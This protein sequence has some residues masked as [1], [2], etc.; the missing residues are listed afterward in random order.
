MICE[1]FSYAIM[2]GVLPLSPKNNINSKMALEYTLYDVLG[3]SVLECFACCAIAFLWLDIC[4]NAPRRPRNA[5]Q[6]WYYHFLAPVLKFML[7]FLIMTALAAGMDGIKAAVLGT[8]SSS[9]ALVKIHSTIQVIVWGLL[10]LVM[11]QCVNLT[12]SR[13]LSITEDNRATL[14]QKAVLPMVLTSM[15]CLL[16][17]IWLAVQLL[18]GQSTMQSASSSWEYW[19]GFVWFPTITLVVSTLYAA[20][21]RDSSSNN[22]QI[23]GGAPGNDNDLARPLLMSPVPPSE[24]FMSFRNQSWDT[25]ARGESGDD[26]ENDEE[27]APETTTTTTTTTTTPVAAMGTKKSSAEEQQQ[28]VAQSQLQPPAKEPPA[29]DNRMEPDAD[30]SQIIDTPDVAELNL[31]M[32]SSCNQDKPKSEFS[33]AQLK[34]QVS[35]RKCKV[36]VESN[37]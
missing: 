34:K 32:C 16:R 36:C 14:L 20:R 1:V 5:T 6:P 10:S 37:A 7:V 31:M 28:Q 25:P 26:D 17:S 23:P 29:P 35:T 9:S 18:R 33:K 4:C 3:R 27:A 15:V 8:E 13:I 12:T 11:L 21:K 24:A 19:I 30:S 2:A 22:N